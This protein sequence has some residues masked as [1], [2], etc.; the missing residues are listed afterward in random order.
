MSSSSLPPRPATSNSRRIAERLQ[1]AGIIVHLEQALG[2]NTVMELGDALAATPIG[3]VLVALAAPG[4]LRTLTL[5]RERVGDDILVGVSGCEGENEA[6]MAIES[7]AQYLIAP[8]F[9]PRTANY[10]YKY[11]VLY[12]PTVLSRAEVV[13]NT[14]R[15]YALQCFYPAEILGPDYLAELQAAAPTSA[16]LV[17]GEIGQ[18]EV[19]AYVQ[20]GAVGL[21]VSAM[22]DERTWWTQTRIIE[23]LR[24][25]RS[26]WTQARLQASTREG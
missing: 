1:Q 14:A 15:G 6:K 2:R 24:M 25:W 23:Q 18:K 22:V 7:G 13:E 8:Y 21:L 16:L 11:D 9:R 26:I 5:L 3:A 12:V 17:G 10:A 4:S 20:A 19:E